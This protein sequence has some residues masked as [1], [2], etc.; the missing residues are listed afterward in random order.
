MLNQRVFLDSRYVPALLSS[1]R[2]HLN[3]K[4]CFLNIIMW[5][6]WKHEGIKKPNQY[7]FYRKYF[8]FSLNIPTPLN[9]IMQPEFLK[10]T[11]SNFI[12]LGFPAFFFYLVSQSHWTLNIFRKNVAKNVRMY[13][14]LYESYLF[15]YL[16]GERE[17]WRIVSIYFS[18]IC[19]RSLSLYTCLV[20]T[21]SL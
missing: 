5:C 14:Y 9:I 10:L 15:R 3:S 1:Y 4:S 11:V 7:N 18:F 19:K 6:F 2:S 8:A 17:H 16:T 13:T 12:Y 20:C 21:A